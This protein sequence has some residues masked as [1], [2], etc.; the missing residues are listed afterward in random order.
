MHAIRLFSLLILCFLYQNTGAQNC[1]SYPIL[2]DNKIITWGTFSKRGDAN[3]SIVSKT[4]NVVKAGNTVTATVKTEVFDKK[5]KS[6]NSSTNYVKCDNGVV[7]MDMRF[8]VPQQQ[9]EQFNRAGAHAKNVYLEYPLNMQPGDQLKGGNFDIDVDN[10]GLKQKLE[11]VISNRVVTGTE[12][13]S[14]PS[15]TWDCVTITYHVN[16]NIQTGPIAIPL[17]MDVT[18]WYAPS[19]GIVKTMHKA[20]Y[21]E[22]LSVK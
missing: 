22:L 5:N 19:F 15:G 17:S 2:Q 12:T 9:S 18:E 16:L 6:I 20:G 4:S 13:L 3:G 1:V 8:Y 10:N 14:L 7:M 11:M 21:T